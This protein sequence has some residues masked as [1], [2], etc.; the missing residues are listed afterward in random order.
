MTEKLTCCECG[1]PTRAPK[2]NW[3]ARK[4]V[5]CKSQTCRR[6]RKTALQKERRRQKELDSLKKMPA[7]KVTSERKRKFYGQDAN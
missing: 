1:K 6:K 2:G 7:R 3:N 5:L 4:V